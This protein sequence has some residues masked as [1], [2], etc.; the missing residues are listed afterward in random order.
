MNRRSACALLVLAC[1]TGSARSALSAPQV[2]FEEAVGDL[3]SADAAARLRAVRLLKDAGYPE[4]AVPLA[5]LVTDSQDEVQLQAIAAEVNVFLAERVVSRRRVGFIIEVRNEVLAEASFSAGPLALGPRPVPVEV[6]TALRAGA[7][8]ENPRVGLEALYA[9][10]AL[11]AEPGGSTRRALLA[12]SGADLAAFIG[13]PDPAFRYAAVRVIGRVYA[14]R[15]SDPAVES[16]VGDAV[17]AALND[18]DGVVK[19]A[20]MEALG[21]MRYERAVQ[22]LDDLFQYYRNGRMAA[23]ALDAVARIAHP[24]SAPRLAVALASKNGE[25]RVIA[26]E[27]LVRMGDRAQ[28]TT[29]DSALGAGPADDASLV[30]DYAAARLS[31]GSLDPVVSA[32]MKPRLRDRAREYLVD[33][34]GPRLPAFSVFAKDSDPAVRR[35]VADVLGLADLPAALTLA[36]SLLADPDQ[37]VAKAAERAVARLRATTM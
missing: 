19:L 15:P 33:L 4:A 36:E 11:A 29:V 23:A 28:A 27:G 30:K 17:I 22:A 21:A 9:F 31:G 14:H 13:M 6:L 26:A 25:L 2:T 34:V 35:D 18:R 24:G 12:A 7:R 37:Q 3:A 20:A 16:V 32:L 5:A 10:G 1:V 8:D